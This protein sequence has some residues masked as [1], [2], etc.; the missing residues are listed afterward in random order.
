[1]RIIIGALLNSVNGLSYVVVL[2]AFFFFVF[3]IIG[4]Q[5]WSG[6]FD[7]RCFIEGWCCGNELAS[8]A[9]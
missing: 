9:D 5:L 1:M 3:G 7:A 6:L 4:V 2:A 8:L